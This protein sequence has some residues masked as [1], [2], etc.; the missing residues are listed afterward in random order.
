[1]ATKQFP[2]NQ[3]WKIC[4]TDEKFLAAGF[5]VGHNQALQYVRLTV[6]N[7]GISAGSFRVAVY[8]D[9]ALTKLY[10]ASSWR[11]VTS[12]EST[13]PAP[14]GAFW[15]GIWG[16]Q[17]PTAWPRLQAGTVY[18]LAVEAD[19]YTRN[20]TTAYVGFCLDAPE[21]INANDNP[22]RPGLAIEFYGN[23]KVRY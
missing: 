14:Y 1:M 8:T 13:L 20:A 23:R 5:K 9:Q 2:K 11:S 10:A 7:K 4:E 16:F 19:G 12:I 15:R 21:E 18:Y 22:S 6:V 3:L 17:F